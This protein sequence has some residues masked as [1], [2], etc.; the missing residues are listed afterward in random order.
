MAPFTHR[1]NALDVFMPVVN[2]DFLNDDFLRT[3][4]SIPENEKISV[5]LP[6]A[7]SKEQYF[8]S[9]NGLLSD[10]HS[11]ILSK[12][13]ISRVFYES[14]PEDFH[15]VDFFLR[16]SETFPATFVH[17]SQHPESG[18]WAGAT[19]ELL[20]KKRDH[21]LSIMALAGTQA[22]NENHSYEWRNKEMEEHLMVGQHIEEVFRAFN[23]TLAVKEG[24]HTIESGR[25][26]HL[27]TDYIFEETNDL[28]LQQFLSVLH[29]TPAVG[30]LPAESGVDAILKH[31][32]YDR[33]YYC[34]FIG[35]TDFEKSADLYINLRCVQIGND[36]IAVYVGGGITSASD[37]QEEW[38]ETVMKSKTMLENIKP[39]VALH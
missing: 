15:P 20:L 32:G 16:L 29:P 37:P 8:R 26:A 38:Q 35:E 10:I 24:P 7:I 27:S 31:E 17:L 22:R 3:I 39:V 33:R 4:E 21:Q 19:P 18:I 13:I 2:D 14:K 6:E 23:C 1:S 9:L 28:P 5:P 25:V 12:A 34:G 11:G 36:D 30:G